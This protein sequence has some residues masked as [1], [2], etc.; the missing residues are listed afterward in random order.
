M[1][2]VQ[3]KLEVDLLLLK[4]HALIFCL[5]CTNIRI[6]GLKYWSIAIYP[7]GCISHISADEEVN[8]CSIVLQVL[9]F[10]GAADTGEI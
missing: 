10:Y 9:V 4:V 1:R 2:V 6:F 3:F 8:L 5:V 7:L